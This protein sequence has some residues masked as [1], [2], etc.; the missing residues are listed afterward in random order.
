M[1]TN[2]LRTQLFDI[3]YT[4]GHPFTYPVPAVSPNGIFS[5]IKTGRTA[6]PAISWSKIQPHRS[7]RYILEPTKVMQKTGPQASTNLC[8]YLLWL[9]SRQQRSTL[10]RGIHTIPRK[11]SSRWDKICSFV[12][13]AEHPA[14]RLHSGTPRTTYHGT[15]SLQLHSRCRTL[16]PIGLLTS[17]VNWRNAMK[18]LFLPCKTPYSHT[19][20]TESPHP[21]PFFRGFCS[22]VSA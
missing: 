20:Q 9:G 10:F 12:W 11:Q 5:W 3:G 17:R 19:S 22:W 6:W 8:P 14:I 1:A 4:G 15:R 7:N 16:R 21:G 18:Q 13:W 2:K